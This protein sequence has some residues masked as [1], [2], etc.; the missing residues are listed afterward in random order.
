MVKLRHNWKRLIALLAIVCML[1]PNTVF[2]AGQTSTYTTYTFDVN[3]YAV[4]SP[5]AY[6]FVEEYDGRTLGIDELN[7]PSDIHVDS[8]GQ[9]YIVDKGNNRIVVLNPDFTVKK[10]VGPF[11]A[12]L[13]GDLITDNFHNPS[14]VYV[15]EKGH[16]YVA[17]TD[18]NRVVEFDENLK[19]VRQIGCPNSKILG[20]DYVFT[21][22][23]IVV[24][25]S[26]RIYLMIQ[27]ENQGIVELEANGSFIGYY[28]AQKVEQS[29]FD[30]IKTLFMTKEQKSRIAR[31]IPRTYNSITID[32]KDF[33]WL[34]SNSLTIYQRKKYMESKSSKD[35]PIKRLNPSG[36]DVLA[37]QG[38]Y[39]PGGDL[40]EV[41]SLVDVAV[42]EN[43][44]YSVLDNLRNRIFT[45]D[46]GGNLLYAFGGS[47][48]QDGCITQAGAIA[49]CGNDIL[50]LDIGDGTIVRY[51][52]TEYAKSIQNAIL[53]DEEKDFEKSIEH[54]SKVLEENQNLGLA[55]E[56]MGENY[57]RLGEYEKAMEYYK[58]A[59]EKDGYSKAFQYVRTELVK[60]NFF[61]VIG[62]FLLVLVVWLFFKSWVNKENKKLYPAGTK[63]TLRSELLY[64]FRAIYHP[65][66]GFWEIKTQRRGTV[67]SAS[68]IL[69]LVILT[70]CYKKVGTGYL[71]RS[72]DI[73]Q[74]DIPI[75]ILK[76]LIPLLLWCISS[77]GLTTL[78]D[79]KGSIKDIYVM[80]CY[81]MF[82]LIF[83]NIIT[84]V[85]SNGMTLA[86]G[87][88]IS[89]ITSLGFVWMV[90]LMFV[91]SMVVQDYQFNKNLGMIIASIVGMA[92]VLFLALLFV[93]V[94]QKMVDFMMA[95]YEEVVY[96]L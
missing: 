10:I 25:S 6:Q 73:E 59:S 12:T 71:F 81:S 63:H 18:N 46:E 77:W 16:M 13:S 51:G 36:S 70:F 60:E 31:T 88:F 5:D 79:G 45:Y 43:G 47:S 20:D 61:V 34:T 30:W 86:E 92:V 52:M 68:I 50:V 56:S 72:I 29:F 22:T 54:W 33:V 84:T 93:T 76:V 21:P 9:I 80:S 82:P 66:D 53:A 27:N 8:Q 35:A 2:A 44:V 15:T 74:V 28:G 48:T 23:A 95:L 89:F 85:M 87:D 41:S 39:A 14:S 83:T 19:F 37:R 94:G 26:D 17:D 57:L 96:R 24:D 67:R 69:F 65:F 64:A 1:F 3:G 75:V 42:K 4:N 78:F 40:L 32:D 62:V 49:Y 55:Y 11:V 90:G 7:K 58:N 38:E 91:G